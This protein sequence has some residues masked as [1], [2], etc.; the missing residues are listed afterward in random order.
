MEPE[1]REVTRFK[2]RPPKEEVWFYENANYTGK[3]YILT[4]GFY[5]LKTLGMDANDF[6]SS[7]LIPRGIKVFVFEDDDLKGNCY[8]LRP[9]YKPATS[10]FQSV[11]ANFEKVEV[12]TGK[13]TLNQNL[14]GFKDINDKISSIVV[15]DETQDFA[16]LYENQFYLGKAKILY[17]VDLVNDA[18]NNV[19]GTWGY[20]TLAPY[21]FNNILS[22]L[23]ANGIVSGY[24]IFQENNFS[25]KSKQFLYNVPNLKDIGFSTG[26]FL[27]IKNSDWND[28]ASSILLYFKTGK[29]I[30]EN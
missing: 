3:K 14:I 27:D 13:N 11:N 9:D 30:I 10:I 24:Q 12:L 4:R 1:N 2:E 7:A 22:S 21:N 19:A 23:K 29:V 15:F 8:Q 26:A 5:S 20:A 6:F 17:P 16:T 18:Y 28:R 25:G